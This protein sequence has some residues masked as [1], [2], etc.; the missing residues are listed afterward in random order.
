MSFTG[1]EGE[2]VTIG[3]AQD[4]TANYRATIKDGETLSHFFGRNRIDEILNQT[5]CM[6]I[7]AYYGNE[8]GGGKVLVLVG[9]DANED[10][11]ENGVIIN[12]S[13][14]CPPICGVNNKLNSNI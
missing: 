7:R 9:A 14:K 5:G 6:G 10:D 8:V 4:W 11:M 3:E 13:V 2:A 12:K 1:N